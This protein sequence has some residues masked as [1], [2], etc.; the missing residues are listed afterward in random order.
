MGFG[1]LRSSFGK[2]TSLVFK[3]DENAVIRHNC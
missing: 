3:W 2:V 1:V